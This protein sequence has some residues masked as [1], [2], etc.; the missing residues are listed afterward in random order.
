MFFGGVIQSAVKNA[1]L[2]NAANNQLKH[3]GGLAGAIATYYTCKLSGQN[4]NIQFGQVVKEVDHKYNT[5]IV[6]AIG[7]NANS[8]TVEHPH[9]SGIALTRALALCDDSSV[10]LVPLLSSQIFAP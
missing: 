7:P 10:P 2:V 5:T 1:Q 8:A 4:Q 3:T 9:A 6:H